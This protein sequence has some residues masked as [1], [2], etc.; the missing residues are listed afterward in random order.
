MAFALLLAFI[1]LLGFK[2]Q[3]ATKRTYLLIGVAALVVSIWEYLA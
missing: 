1:F 2:G 3:R